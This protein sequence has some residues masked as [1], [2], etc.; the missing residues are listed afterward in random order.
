MSVIIISQGQPKKGR[1]KKM[2]EAMTTET[3]VGGVLKQEYLLIHEHNHCQ[4]IFNRKKILFD[5]YILD[6]YD[7]LE[8][9]IK[10]DKALAEANGLSFESKEIY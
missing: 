4:I 10:S 9:Q 1:Y 6:G 3:L 5:G 2:R 7:F 8:K